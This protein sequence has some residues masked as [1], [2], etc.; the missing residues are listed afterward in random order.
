MFFLQPNFILAGVLLM[1]FYAAGKEE[2]KQGKRDLG[3]FWA[4]CSAIVSGVVIGVFNGQWL[5]V[6]IAQLGLFIAI[7]LW[8]TVFDKR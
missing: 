4:L 1:A 3:M 6:L 5:P 7:G 8:R 2:A